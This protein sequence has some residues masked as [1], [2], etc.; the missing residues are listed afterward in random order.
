MQTNKS[1]LVLIHGHGVDASIWDG[2]YAVLASDAPVIRP[3]FSRLTSH[4]TI[5][6]YA[7]EL[8]AQVQS[9]QVDKVVLAGHSMG[10]YV[11][12]A[13]ADQHP[14]MIKGLV[15]FHSTAIAD[16]E[17]RRVV[18]RQAIEG[19]VKEGTVPFIQ[20]QMPKMV[21]SSYA[22]EKTQVLIDRFSGLP[23]DALIAGM[24]A[25]LNRPDRTHVLRNAQFPVLVI[26]G[27]DDQVIPYEK[28]VQMADLSPQVSVTSIE[29]AG[30]LGMIEQPAAAINALQSFLGEL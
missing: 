13:F 22:S 2:I 18:R 9:A 7:E 12:L 4:T 5:E 25:M 3:D 24:T 6:A 30:H 26:L 15:L 10:G 17:N 29:Q 14:E 23:A 8:F 1:V 20:K 16:D 28:A 21:S 19:L 27:R 11:A